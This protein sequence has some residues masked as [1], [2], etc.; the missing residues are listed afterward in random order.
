MREEFEII[1]HCAPYFQDS[2]SF[3][4]VSLCTKYPFCLTSLW[5]HFLSSVL[6]LKTSRFIEVPHNIIFCCHHLEILTF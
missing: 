4:R 2:K 1:R 5:A 6:S 3:L